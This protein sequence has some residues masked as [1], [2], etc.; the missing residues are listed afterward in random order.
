MN[1]AT[2]RNLGAKAGEHAAIHGGR[3]AD[4]AKAV[5]LCPGRDSVTYPEFCRA[6]DLAWQKAFFSQPQIEEVL[7]ATC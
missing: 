4:A 2:A 3:M 6:Y 1:R 7:N 5:G